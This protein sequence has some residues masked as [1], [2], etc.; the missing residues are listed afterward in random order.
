VSVVILRRQY[1][2]VSLP[3]DW[4]VI[5]IIISQARYITNDI[6]KQSSAGTFTLAKSWRV[7]N[8]N[9]ALS[10]HKPTMQK[11]RMSPAYR[12]A[13]FVASS[14]SIKGTYETRFLTLI[15]YVHVMLAIWKFTQMLPRHKTLLRLCPRLQ[16]LWIN[17]ISPKIGGY[18]WYSAG[19]RSLQLSITLEQGNK[20]PAYFCD[21]I[22]SP[23]S[24]ANFF[25]T[26]PT[27]PHRQQID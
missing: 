7:N 17:S 1:E 25:R 23:I 14:V 8:Q 3:T 12:R 11:V 16:R 6:S 15:R 19:H 21:V 2:A 22:R 13:N 4:T 9:F 26:W 18:C 24:T 27:A 20:E 5:Q 10:V